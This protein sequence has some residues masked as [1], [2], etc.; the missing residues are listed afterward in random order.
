MIARIFG[1][2]V[3][4]YKCMNEKNSTNAAWRRVECHS[5]LFF[6]VLKIPLS[7][8]VSST[9]QCQDSCRLC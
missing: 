7:G 9:S 1:V 3:S 4:C 6:L 2:H 8:G 5:G